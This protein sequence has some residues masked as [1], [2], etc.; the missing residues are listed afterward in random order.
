MNKY[1]TLVRLVAFVL[2]VLLSAEQAEARLPGFLQR[3]QMGYSFVVASADYTTKSRFDNSVFP[4]LNIDTTY[5]GKLNTTAA[6]GVTAGTFIPLKRLGQKSS[7]N[8]TIDYVYNAMTWGATKDPAGIGALST[9]NYSGMTVQMG[10]PVGLD[11]K[12]GADAVTDKAIRFCTSFGAGV[13][14]SYNVTTLDL[15]FNIDPIFNVNPYVK[16]EV[17]IFAGICWKFRAMY[18]LLDQKYL[19]YKSSEQDAFSFSESNAEM[20]AKSHLTL[21]VIIMPFS[22]GWKRSEW[23]NT[24]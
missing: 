21:S 7:L 16:A 5:T 20:K 24:Y 6:F 3:Y 12:L 9:F 13:T 14:P 23:W 15:N 19:T 1:P 8:L 22:W 10:L 4:T 11:L 18:T 17:G 2:V